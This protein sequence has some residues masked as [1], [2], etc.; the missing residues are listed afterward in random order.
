MILDFHIHLF[1]P[2][3][4]RNRARYFRDPQFQF[5]YK[6]KGAK[7]L[8]EKD[9]YVEMDAAGVDYSV[10]MGFPW[11]EEEFCEEQISFFS[12]MAR[13][14]G[15]RLLPFGSVP[16]AE[17]VSVERRVREIRD[18]GLYGIGEIAFY[19]QGMTPQHEKYLRAVLGAACDYSLP[20]CLHLNEPVG[21]SYTGKYE[22]GFSRI[23][24]MLSDYPDA[25]II[26]AHWGG[27]LLFYELMPEVARS[28]KNCYYDTAASPYLYAN[29][30]FTIA[31]DITGPGK[32][33]FGS[34]FPLISQARYIEIIEKN[35]P[36]KNAREQILGGN[37]A[38][39][40]GLA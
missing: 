12:S 28:L 18:L 16:L 35:V 33:L 8:P 20:V 15:S 38:R 10:A 22:P 6:D 34:D 11:I 19:L 37:G 23:Y 25:T 17:G 2:G 31:P 29:R 26:L 39:I 5:L 40:L 36:D 24:A 3:V 27:G 4:I 14:S 21:H 9:V 13:G 30:I 1:Q 7:I 32:I